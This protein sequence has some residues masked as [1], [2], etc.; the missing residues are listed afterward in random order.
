MKISIFGLGYV[1]CVSMGCLAKN[2]HKIIGVDNN[3]T[4]VRFVGE[5]KSPIVEP[6]IDTILHQ[7]IKLG[8]IA[9]ST[10]PIFSVCSTDVSFIAVG[11]PGTGNGHLDFSAVF[12]VAEEI[13]RAVREKDDFHVVAVRSTVLPGTCE[14]I[15]SII[16]EKSR[17]LPGEDFSVVSN[18]EFLREG[19]AVRDY[20]NPSYTLIGSNNQN[21]VERMKAVYCG[22]DAPIVVVERRIA[23]M[24][25]YVNN[26]FH[27]LKISFANEVGNICKSL[28]IDSHEL[29][30]VFCMD[31][32]LNISPYYFKPGFSYGGSCLPKDLKALA[33]IAHD[34]YLKCPVIESIDVSNEV[35]KEVVLNRILSF[36]KQKLGFLGLSFKAG[37]DDLRSSPIVDVIE[38]LLGKGFEIKIFDRNVHLSQLV[39]ANR[40]FIM[41][42]I[43]YISRFITSNANEV[44]DHAEVIIIVNNED[45]F[46]DM[47]NRLGNGK[48]VYDLVNLKLVQISDTIDYKGLSW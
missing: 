48:T 37:T 36:G 25:K 26:S 5:G 17:K 21:A 2:G 43:P 13:G 39:G 22:V 45:E 24:I 14:K 47:L 9:T 38:K 11:T 46:A 4:K 42:R 15:E 44:F 28:D 35:Q 20:Y 7:Q 34:S 16:A 12:K 23:E 27:A 40:E 31:T 32:K 41:Q 3:E 6:E 30:K 1:G 33:T 10:D 18:P 29:M 19:T 8:N